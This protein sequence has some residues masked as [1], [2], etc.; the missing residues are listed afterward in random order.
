[1]LESVSAVARRHDIVPSQLFTWRR[2]LREQLQGV[3]AGPIATSSEPACF[4]PAIVEPAPA[5]ASMS[6]P[7]R[8]RRQRRPRASV[9]ELEMDGIAVKIAP[10]ADKR[11]IAAVIEALKA[12]R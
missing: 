9:V 4:V 7:K 8:R 10:S 11:L 6:A 5:S 2:E 12:T 1:G 3:T